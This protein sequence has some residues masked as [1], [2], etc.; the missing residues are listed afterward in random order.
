MIDL[1]N[2][3]LS[4]W[5]EIKYDSE[6]QLVDIPK[7]VLCNDLCNK[8]IKYFDGKK[9]TVDLSHRDNLWIY[10]EMQNQIY[11]I[12]IFDDDKEAYKL[13]LHFNFTEKTKIKYYVYERFLKYIQEYDFKDNIVKLFE[14]DRLF[15]EY[16]GNKTIKFLKCVSSG[17]KYEIDYFSN[18]PS[19]C[20]VAI[21]QCFGVH[22]DSFIDAILN[23][24]TIQQLCVRI[25]GSYESM[26]KTLSKYLTHV[27]T[28]RDIIDYYDKLKN[29]D[30]LKQLKITME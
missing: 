4:L 30:S 14:S 20:T 9:V 13:V 8:I 10:F 16:L 29:H 18:F 19:L 3:I 28:K 6:K 11:S 15:P 22:Y 24:K 23:S 12:K 17:S 25:Y 1:I 2:D 27:P 5:K 21:N 7:K 26:Y